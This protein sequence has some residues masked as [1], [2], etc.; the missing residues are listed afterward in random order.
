M[1]AVQSIRVGSACAA[2]SLP[3]TRRL[4]M[5]LAFVLFLTMLPVTMLVPVLREL[6]TERFDGTT[7]WTHAFMSINLVGGLMAAPFGAWLADRHSG[8]KPVFIFAAALDA[9]LLGLMYACARWQPSLSLLLTLRF[10]EGAAHLTSL[11][12]LMALAGDWSGPGRGG[13]VM[14]VIGAA[15]IFGTAFG[16]PLG[17]RIGQENPVF[18]L[19]LGAIICVVAAMLGLRLAEAPS[20]RAP[21][22]LRATLLLLHDFPRLTT[23][24]VFGFIERLCVGV[25]VS[26]FI[27]YL[28]EVQRLE[29]ARKGLLMALFLFPFAILCYPMG[30]LTDRFGRA[31]PMCAGG[32]AFGLVYALYGAVS[33][34]WLV[35]LMLLSGVL[36][37]V[38]FAPNLA[39]CAD[40]APP[41]QKAA[42]FAGFN[43]AG[44]LGFLCGPLLGGT[45]MSALTPRLGAGASYQATFAI[46]GA[47][48]VVCAAGSLPHLLA[49]RR[50]RLTR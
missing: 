2:P 20:R 18:V 4:V 44:S 24:Y 19:L 28:G 31:I 37:A 47:I 42:A 10:L 26:T 6:V 12:T 3:A 33:G 46:T 50:H 23:A 21:A 7:F 38:M 17:G 1:E 32:I 25:I 14:G 16:T 36:S 48:V 22:S 40:L 29:P 34:P 41:D 43:M 9:T 49:L 27:L 45:L 8:R 13:R 39:M 15:L 35:V 5:T 30:R 11:S